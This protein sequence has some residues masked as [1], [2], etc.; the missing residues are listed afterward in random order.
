MGA[1]PPAARR[2]VIADNDPAV[3]ELL[4]TDLRAEGHEIV[5]TVTG[6]EDAMERC[7][8]LR[9]D[10]LVLDYRMPPGPNGLEVAARLRRDLPGI[11]VVLYTNYRDARLRARAK[12]LG[13]GVF[14]KG[15][16]RALRRAVNVGDVRPGP[17][18][19][20]RS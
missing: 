20:E 10:V 2:I 9:P 16:L 13:V 5:A 7:R 4:A 19:R 18:R 3:I 12:R 6:G 8:S 14:A 17:A 1:P 15:N 11:H